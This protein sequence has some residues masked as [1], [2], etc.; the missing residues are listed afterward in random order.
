MELKLSQNEIGDGGA[1]ALQGQLS[2]SNVR[3]LD[4]GANYIDGGVLAR[5]RMS[6]NADG[7]SVVPGSEPQR[8][9]HWSS[10]APPHRPAR[11]VMLERDL[12]EPPP[13]PRIWSQT[14]EVGITFRVMF[15]RPCR[16]RLC[17]HH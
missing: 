1:N 6:R 7:E 12:L 9:R 2:F 14:L 4:L 5:L 8:E 3:A 17:G 10:S 16:H 15:S 11:N 13:P